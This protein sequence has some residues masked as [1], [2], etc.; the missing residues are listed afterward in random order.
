MEPNNKEFF[1]RKDKTG[2]TCPIDVQVKMEKMGCINSTVHIEK[3]TWEK[4]KKNLEG[5]E[6]YMGI[7]GKETVIINRLDLLDME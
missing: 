5:L 3:T 1:K 4:F 6:T 7:D 2:K